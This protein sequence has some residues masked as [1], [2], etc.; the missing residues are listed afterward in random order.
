MTYALNEAILSTLAA[1]DLILV[2]RN[3]KFN[4][5]GLVSVSLAFLLLAAL[6]AS[7]YSVQ[8]TSHHHYIILSLTAAEANATK[9]I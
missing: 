7:V 1:Y 5:F 4:L 6:F 3:R 9:P 2:E 8:F